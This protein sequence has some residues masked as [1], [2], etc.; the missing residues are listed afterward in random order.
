MRSL[1]IR[2]TALY[3]RKSR[4]D[5]ADEHIGD[6]LRRHKE[7]LLAFAAEQGLVIEAI[8]EEVVSGDSLYTRPQMLRLLE[9]VEQGRFGAVLCMDLDR[10]GRGGMSDQGIILETL[11]NADTKI[12][13]PRKTYDLRNELDEEYTEFETFLARRELKLIKRRLQR[14]IRKTVEDGGYLAN[15]PYG[16]EKATVQKQPSLKIREEEA[17]FV[18][19]AF[20][21]Y[22]TEKHGCQAIADELNRLGAKPRRAPAFNRSGILRIL[23]NPVYCGKVAW[24]RQSRVR[25]GNQG[26]SRVIANPKESWTVVDGL[27]PAIIDEAV[28][29][30]AQ[31]ILQSRSQTSYF[32]GTVKNP[33]AGLLYCAKCGRPLQRRPFSG[34]GEPDW[35]VC[36]T[37]GCCAAS[38]LDIV[39]QAVLETV[40]DRWDALCPEP[41]LPPHSTVDLTPAIAACERER[42]R[43]RL[44]QS[45]L[46]DLLEQG[47]YD[48][49]TFRSR[50]TDLKRQETEADNALQ[51][52]QDRQ[53]QAGQDKEGASRA[54]LSVSDVYALAGPDGRN[55]LLK[56]ALIRGHYWK[57]KGWGPRQFRL[58]L[59]LRPIGRQT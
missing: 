13:T 31:A 35:L 47:V 21:L 32:D 34:R 50:M 3:L 55:R 8:Y 23:K 43:L 9:E 24:N 52:L 40:R 36:P 42:D 37:R 30:R 56:A 17:A 53:I 27:H 18:R 26:G 25:T 48:T 29:D 11:K 41:V 14:G 2:N 54:P 49:D 44:Q 10:L 19:L 28:F 45:R 1:V 15:A 12:V 16:Y 6:T 51:R 39:E 4:V 38:R 59:E 58:F 20:D 22:N 33:L 7:T 5:E 46:H 57:E